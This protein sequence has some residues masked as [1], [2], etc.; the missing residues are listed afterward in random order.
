MATP[1]LLT[2]LLRPGSYYKQLADSIEA[3]QPKRDIVP[4]VTAFPHIGGWKL[5]R[6][7]ELKSFSPA[8]IESAGV[9][10]RPVWTD[11][12]TQAAIEDGYD[13]STWVFVAIDKIARSAASLPLIVER[14]VAG[15]ADQWQPAT[16]T[17]LPGAS[18]STER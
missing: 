6:P 18:R 8:Q 17:P 12:D 3:D 7:D 13:A 14:R 16:D 9:I 15:D 2:R 5:N 10:G 4:R 1:G 11:W